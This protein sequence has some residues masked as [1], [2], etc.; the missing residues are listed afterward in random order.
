M[1]KGRAADASQQQGAREVDVGR[2]IACTVEGVIPHVPQLAQRAVDRDLAR[3]LIKGERLDARQRLAVVSCQLDIVRVKRERPL[4]NARRF[5][6]GACLDCPRR[7][8]VGVSIRK[9]LIITI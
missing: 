4:W 3:H 8:F 2:G 5:R 7:N 1:T 9:L 6:R